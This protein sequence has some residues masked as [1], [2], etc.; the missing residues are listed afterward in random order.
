APRRRGHPRRRSVGARPRGVVMT[1]A[2]A[3]PEGP[4]R[5]AAVLYRTASGNRPHIPACP[6]VGGTLREAGAAERLAMTVC[7][8]CQAEL[9]GVGRTYFGSLDDAMRAFGSH[10]G[11]HGLIRDALR[12]V[13]YDQ[14]WLPYSKSYIALGHQGRGVA[15]V[16]KT[17]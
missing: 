2:P 17:Y 5:P 13:T 8:W 16:G 11:T 14:I 6:P 10:V 7:S 4:S 12:F 1:E 3:C 15:W 9:D